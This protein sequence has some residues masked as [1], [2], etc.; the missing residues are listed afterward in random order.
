MWYVVDGMDGC[1]KSSAAEFI[2]EQLGSKGR[3]VLVI[4]HPNRDTKIGKKEADYLLQDGKYPKTMATLLYILDVM[5]SLRL[6]KKNRK[7]KDYDDI[8]FVRYIMAVSYVPEPL[9][10]YAYNFFCLVFPE[11]DVKLMIDVDGPTAM[12]RINSRGDALESFETEKQLTGIRERMLG[13]IPDGWNLIDNN[14]TAENTKT[15]ILKVLEE[16][17]ALEPRTGW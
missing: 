1:G 9:S 10:K 2:S 4:T 7:L 3:K 5:H 17:G 13:F 15:Q 12:A 8:V 11:P 6:L 16:R 14:G